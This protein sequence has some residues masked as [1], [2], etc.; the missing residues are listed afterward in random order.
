MR[1]WLLR[2]QRLLGQF[3]EH[4]KAI[5]GICVD[6]NDDGLVHSCSLD[7]SILTF[8]LR[9]EKRANCHMLREG[10]FV[11]MVQRKDHEWELIT[12]HGAGV[13][14]QWDCDIADAVK[15][16]ED[17]RRS[18]CKYLAM[19]PSGRFLACACEDF[20]VKIWDVQADCVISVCLGHSVAVLAVKWSPDEKQFVSVSGDCSICVWNFY[21]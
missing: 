17:P 16:W 12:S 3:A 9:T 2:N 19:S 13:M 14:L 21:A 8:D 20:T 15:E 5:T 18:Q 4:A 6:I 1:V 7:K 10:S 11:H